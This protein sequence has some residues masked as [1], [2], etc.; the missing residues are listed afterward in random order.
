MIFAG[1]ILIRRFKYFNLRLY[2]IF[3][4]HKT[5]IAAIFFDDSGARRLYTD[6]C[7]CSVSPLS[8][9]K[10]TRNS[11]QGGPTYDPIIHGPQT[12]RVIH[13]IRF[14]SRAN[15]VNAT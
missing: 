11:T 8:C 13:N 14:E 4:K 9:R 5:H 12:G 15:N 3:R 1:F 10:T 7:L 6:S 2:K